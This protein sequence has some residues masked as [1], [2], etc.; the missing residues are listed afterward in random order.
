MLPRSH[1]KTA[2]G[3]G[4]R[5]EDGEDARGE[6]WGSDEPRWRGMEGKDG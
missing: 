3:A 5:P 6:G 2:A 1:P 4:G